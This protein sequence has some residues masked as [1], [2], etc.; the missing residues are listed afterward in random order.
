M[1]NTTP[2]N[3]TAAN[4]RAY[5]DTL[6]DESYGEIMKAIAMA[7]AIRKEKAAEAVN[8]IDPFAIAD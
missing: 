6:D 7:A 2:T 3:S 5:L 8:H 1:N 4:V